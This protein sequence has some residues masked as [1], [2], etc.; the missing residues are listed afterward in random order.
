MA[1]KTSQPPVSTDGQRP[2]ETPGPVPAI[3]L[4]LRRAPACRRNL[5]R[6]V[7]GAGCVVRACGWSLR[8]PARSRRFPIF[9]LRPS[10]LRGALRTHQ[11]EPLS[12]LLQLLLPSGVTAGD[13]ARATVAPAR[14]GRAPI[15][16]E[17]AVPR[18]L[19]LVVPYRRRPEGRVR[20]DCPERRRGREGSEITPAPRSLSPIGSPGGHGDDSL[21][22]RS[23]HGGAAR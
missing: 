15:G 4:S 14:A 17:T 7:C 20:I 13:R 21:P 12:A 1:A 23:G 8:G 22:G 11:A 2:G 5:L 16:S 19:S 10:R 18:S 3:P 6:P 9:S